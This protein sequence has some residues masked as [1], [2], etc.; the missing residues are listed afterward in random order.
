MP[1]KRINVS[2]KIFKL[3][4]SVIRTTSTATP[5]L[6]HRRGAGSILRVTTSAALPGSTP[7]NAALSGAA[8]TDAALPR[9]ALT[10]ATLSRTAPTCPTLPR[11]ARTRR[12]LRTNQLRVF[13]AREPEPLLTATT[14][15]ATA[16]QSLPRRAGS[17]RNEV[18]QPIARRPAS[19]S[20][21]SSQSRP[22]PGPVIPETLVHHQQTLG[23]GNRQH[24][25]GHQ[26]ETHH[27]ALQKWISRWLPTNSTGSSYPRRPN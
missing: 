4:L 13:A 27:V 16:S 2:I 14:A 25:S 1:R 8:L 10:G 24:H 9:T 17:V 6:G 5:A 21:S 18:R 3:V 19:G 12:D 23:T 7:T 20:A 15:R 26:Y 11:T 22:E